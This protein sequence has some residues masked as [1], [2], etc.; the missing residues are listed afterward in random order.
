MKTLTLLAGTALVAM[1]AMM[2]VAANADTVKTEVVVK[3]QD[4]PNRNKVYFSDFDLNKDG[5]LS[6]WEVGERLFRSFDLDG[7]MTIDNQEFDKKSVLAIVPVEK[8]TL[9]MVD[10]NDDGKSEVATYTVETFMQESGLA[11]FTQGSPS[12]SPHDFIGTDY[13]VI[14]T[15]RN[16]FIELSEWKEIYAKVYAHKHDN[17]KIYNK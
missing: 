3:Q 16:G 10:I 9:K 5:I 2:P 14:D 1:V 12:I 15:S 13:K 11:R 8:E 7:N 17:P 4:I 6:R